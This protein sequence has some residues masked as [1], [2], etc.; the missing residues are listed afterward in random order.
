M[1]WKNIKNIGFIKLYTKAK[2]RWIICLWM[3][4]CSKHCESSQGGVMTL[5]LLLA[6]KTTTKK[7]TLWGKHLLFSKTYL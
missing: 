6:L 7:L 2:A 5:K 1:C 3:T 4:A